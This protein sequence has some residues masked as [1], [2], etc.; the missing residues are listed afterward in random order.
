[1]QWLEADRRHKVQSLVLDGVV[2]L[3]LEVALDKTE[4]RPPVVAI[5][6]EEPV[7]SVLLAHTA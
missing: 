4:R 5:E 1:M 6:L 3:A 7:V 2:T